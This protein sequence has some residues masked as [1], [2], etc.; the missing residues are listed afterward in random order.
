MRRFFLAFLLC[1]A[2][3]SAGAQVINN[4]GA[5]GGGGI[6]IGTTA[7]T[8]GTAN[9]ILYDNAG[10]VGEIIK[11]NSGVYQTNGSGVPSCGT[12]LPS[13]VGYQAPTIGSTPINSG[14]TV[15]TIAGLTLTS[16]TLTTPN[17]NVATATTVNKWTFTAPTTSATLTA[18]ADN[19]VYTGPAASKTLAANDLSNVTLSQDC[20]NSNA[21]ITCAKTNNVAFTAYATAAIG[22]LP[23]TAT[24]DNANAGN[25]GEF[26]NAD[27]NAASATVTISNASPAVITWTGHGLKAGATVN[28]TTTGALPTGLSVGT[29]YWVIAA[30]LTANTFEVSTSPFGA[31]V[32]TS[33]AGSGTQTGTAAALA[34]SSGT[35]QNLCALSLTAGDWDVSGGVVY[36]SPGTSASAWA[37]GVN[38][39]SASLPTLASVISAGNGPV[40]Q[41]AQAAIGAQQ[42]FAIQPARLSL[43]AT[44]TVFEVGRMTYTGTAPNVFCALSARRRR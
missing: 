5:G 8:G 34:A 21:V 32:N 41:L 28:F 31:A 7:I 12:T 16:P 17:L 27:A 43:N 33:S 13:G 42:G 4:P 40:V 2:A 11:C 20:T 25:D 35:T 37:V 3:L 6:T 22:Q 30:G 23:G 10:A 19:V 36:P 9:Q 24:N 44:T 38:L 14:A 29:N 15:T 1:A 39:T 18:G 26:V